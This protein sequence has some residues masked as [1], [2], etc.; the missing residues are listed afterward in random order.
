MLTERESTA[1]GRYNERAR[2]GDTKDLPVWVDANSA[3]IFAPFPKGGIV[4]DAGCGTG[5][6]ISLLEDLG[7]QNYLGIDPAHEQIR[8]ARKLHPSKEFAVCS[9]AGLGHRYPNTFDG[10]VLFAVLMH[11]DRDDVPKALA[12]LRASLKDGAVGM[13]STPRGAGTAPNNVG[14]MLT[15]FDF[16]EMEKLLTGA[17]FEV[18]HLYSPSGQMLLGGVRAI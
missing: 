2:T 9:I 13:F 6:A 8:L 16:D 3:E 1:V 15:L 14:L 12:S 17:G 18:T 7:I 4:L 11:M 5:R 10:F